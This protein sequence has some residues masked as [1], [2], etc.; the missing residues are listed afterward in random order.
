MTP[1]PERPDPLHLVDLRRQ[2]V[3]AN[4]PYFSPDADYE[5]RLLFA[6]LDKAAASPVTDAG[7][8]DLQRYSLEH[9]S[10]FDDWNMEPDPIG[11]YVLFDDVA[12]LSRQAE[13]E[14][15]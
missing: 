12:A 1:A 13:K 5:V 10:V 9:D 15:A 2:T 8:D 4:R 3:D 6:E 14:T 11:R 7:L